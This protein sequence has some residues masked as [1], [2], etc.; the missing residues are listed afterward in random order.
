MLYEYGW[1][2]NARYPDTTQFCL[3]DLHERIIFRK[4]E[5]LSKEQTTRIEKIYDISDEFLH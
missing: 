4:G 3:E 1:I 2:K 5:K